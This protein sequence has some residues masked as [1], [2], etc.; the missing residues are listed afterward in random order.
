MKILREDQALSIERLR[1]AIG[2][3]VKRVV[4]ASPTGSGKT[5]IAAS[6]VDRAMEKDKRVLVTV[7][8]L[9]LVDQ[10][11]EAFYN[12]GITEVG[13]IQANHFRTDWSK[14]VQ[15][16]SVA[17]LARREFP[18]ADVQ[19][20][21]ECHIMAK[22]IGKL[23]LDPDRRNIV[24]IGLSATPFSKGLGK[25]YEELIVGNTTQELID[26][27][28]L[29]PF[30]IFA[31]SHPDLKGV[32]TIAGEYHENDLAERMNKAKL[33]ADIVE[34]WKAKGENR[35]TI[36]F[37][38]N[39]A[40]AQALK[41]K[42]EAEGV[43]AGYM[44][45]DTSVND[46]QELRRRFLNGNIRVVCNVDV[47]G[48]GI[49]WPE[50]SCISYC[51]PTK[52]KTRYL[53]NMGRGLRK[54]DGKQDL[55]VLDHSDTTLRLG[56]IT[57]ITVDALD[58]GRPNE[59]AKPS[60][61]LPKEC[62]SCTYLKPPKCAVCPN[63]GFTSKV[64]S[65]VEVKAGA[66]EELKG[67]KPSKIA[68]QF[69]KLE[70]YGQLLWYAEH[71][72]Y[73]P[74][75]AANKYKTIFDVWPRGMDGAVRRPPSAELSSWIVSSNIRY[76]KGR[77]R[78]WKNGRDKDFTPRESQEVRDARIIENVRKQFVPGTLCTDDDLEVKW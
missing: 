56:F 57:D 29:S 49:D 32:R 72:G 9:S 7:P 24:S 23:L 42:F 63:C 51:R 11:V 54:S 66:L 65:K 70:V 18:K 13:V 76:V 62:P 6:I 21:D 10:T 12:Q 60:L 35:P 26:Q 52:S 41:E 8:A 3:G 22:V 33:T 27:G 37:A 15:V 19:I 36:C 68:R 75:W 78:A 46:R 28:I 31:P 25:F 73:N 44:D 69:N 20:I 5:V 59:T 30:R 71:K 61:P 40:H 39:R 50:I 17:T 16:A 55:I 64:A 74:G 1:E 48:L 34:T 14:P 38:V 43:P 67:R 77:S 2:R 58:D 47:I 4:L 45:C 53:Q